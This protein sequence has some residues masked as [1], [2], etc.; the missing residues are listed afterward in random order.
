MRRDRPSS[1]LRRRY[2]GRAPGISWSRLATRHDARAGRQTEVL[3][4]RDILTGLH[5]PPAPVASLSHL[6]AHRVWGQRLRLHIVGAPRVADDLGRRVRS[7]HAGSL[8]HAER[9]SEVDVL[10]LVWVPP[11]GTLRHVVVDVRA[12]QRCAHIVDPARKVTGFAFG[13]LLRLP[14]RHSHL[15]CS[16][17]VQRGD[18]AASHVFRCGLVQDRFAGGE[19]CRHLVHRS[20]AVAGNVSGSLIVVLNVRRAPR[21]AGLAP[22]PKLVVHIPEVNIVWRLV[23]NVLPLC[24]RTD[25]TRLS[26]G[27]TD[28]SLRLGDLALGQGSHLSRLL[29]GQSRLSGAKP[30]LARRCARQHP[31]LGVLQVG[32]RLGFL[33]HEIVLAIEQCA[34]VGIEGHG[35]LSSDRLV[36]VVACAVAGAVADTL[37]QRCRQVPIR[38]VG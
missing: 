33:L 5:V 31:R 30:R 3:P 28:P 7:H 19:N 16:H 27:L 29:A 10:P 23:P 13:G 8:G 12:V 32:A 1:T 35:P 37:Y 14:C 24:L 22:C 25:E 6:R 2:V 34:E 18:R 21:I 11:G 26:L 4:Q 38:S 15:R 17:G 36:V 20:I 9:L